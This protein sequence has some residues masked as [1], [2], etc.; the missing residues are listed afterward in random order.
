MGKDVSSAELQTTLARLIQQPGVKPGRLLR[1]LKDAHPEA[2]KGDIVRAAFAS[3][4]ALAD[5][6]PE[7]ALALQDF[8]I[9]S[10]A[11]ARQDEP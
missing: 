10:R 9:A 5:R 3:M 1:Q 11:E 2:T 7:L 4:I 8:A 6:D